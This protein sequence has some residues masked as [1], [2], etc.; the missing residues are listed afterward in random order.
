MRSF[1]RSSSLLPEVRAAFTS[2][3]SCEFIIGMSSGAYTSGVSMLKRVAPCSSG[4]V[5]SSFV[6]ISQAVAF[7]IKP[8]PCRVYVSTPHLLP[9][10]HLIVSR[11]GVGKW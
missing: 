7:P 3:N 2:G 1:I 4:M 8:A 10:G 6:V 11:L 9:C 5:R